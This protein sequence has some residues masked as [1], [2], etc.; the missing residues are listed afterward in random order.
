MHWRLG[1]VA[2]AVPVSMTQKALVGGVDVKH[3]LV[4]DCVVCDKAKFRRLPYFRVPTDRRTDYPPFWC[5]YVDGCGGQRSM[6]VQS[7]GG[8]VGNFIFV[9]ITSGD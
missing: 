2:F 5:I 4:E 1:H 6:G 8:A 9:D 3:L 7:V